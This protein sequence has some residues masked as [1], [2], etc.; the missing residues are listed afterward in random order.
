MK[1]NIINKSFLIHR[2]PLQ[3]DT[4]AKISTFAYQHLQKEKAKA[5]ENFVG[6]FNLYIRLF[7]EAGDSKSSTAKRGDVSYQD[8]L[9]DV[10]RKSYY[11]NDI[12]G[13]KLYFRV[14][15]IIISKCGCNGGSKHLIE[16]INRSKNEVIRLTN[17]KSKNNN[18]IFLCFI[19]GGNMKGNQV[20]PDVIRQKIGLKFGEKVTIKDVEK[21]ADYF[22]IGYFLWNQNWEI[23]GQKTYDDPMNF[24]HIYLRNDHYYLVNITK[25][26]KCKSCGKKMNLNKHKCNINV[27]N[28]FQSQI[29][30]NKSFVRVRKIKHDPIAYEDV[31]HYDLE[32]FQDPKAKCHVPYA[33]GW[34]NKEYKVTYGKDCF[35]QFIDE[36]VKQDN[37]IISAYNGSGFDF[38][39]IIDTLTERGVD[40]TEIILTNGKVMSFKFG[41]N[42]VFDLYLFIMTS[43]DNACKDYKIVNA[44]GSFD[45]EKINEWSDT[46][47]HKKEVLEYL[48][49]DV[50]G[51]KEL[52]EVFSKMMYE[53]KQVDI[54]KF[55]TASHMSYELWAV[56]SII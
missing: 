1:N 26:D 40:V 20:K 23:I 5:A 47:T 8:L 43:L 3:P 2:Y 6:G 31:I 48:R 44:K 24:I 55:I 11:N 30:K 10:T 7:Y 52:F 39:F 34:W 32:T 54:T 29:M 46:E 42:K 35:N 17:A 21:V 36:L 28:Y 37:K 25:Y 50:L 49:L 16:K 38:Y 56:H 18:C 14:M 51:L 19:I 4:A 15:H 41:T 12:P 27:T 13:Y 53:M 33:C 9:E 45:H 22:K